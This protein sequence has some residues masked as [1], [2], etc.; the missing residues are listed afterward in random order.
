MSSAR[1]LAN[2]K[3]Y[4]AKILIDHWQQALIAEQVASTVLEQAFGNPVR[5][6]LVGAY[7]WFLLEVSQPP[8]LPAVPPR[9]CNELAAVVEGLQIAPEILEFQQMERVPWLAQV[10][11]SNPT[12]DERTTVSTHS[13]A[14]ETDAIFT[15]E[16]AMQAGER[17][18]GLFD[19]MTNSLDEY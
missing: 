10:L 3:L 18:S 15:P 13:L 19:R 12:A 17:L 1:A 6:H 14:I 11:G 4:H 5:E 7:G 2:Q 16:L 8:S 9:C